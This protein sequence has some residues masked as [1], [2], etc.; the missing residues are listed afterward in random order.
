[1]SGFSKGLL[2]VT[3]VA[4][5]GVVYYFFF[6]YNAP[7]TGGKSYHGDKVTNYLDSP[8]ELVDPWFG[9]RL[10]S[11]LRFSTTRQSTAG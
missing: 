5:L 3:V 9:C 11:R 4:F 10:A 6:E 8:P 2:F 7:D 1:M